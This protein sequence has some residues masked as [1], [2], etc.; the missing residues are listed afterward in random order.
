MTASLLR[1]PPPPRPPG[2]DVGAVDLGGGRVRNC[3]GG[4]G[5]V[6]SVC[7][8]NTSFLIVGTV[9]GRAGSPITGVSRRARQ[10]AASTKQRAQGYRL[11]AHPERRRLR[12]ARALKPG[13]RGAGTREDRSRAARRRNDPGVTPCTA[14]TARPGG[15][16]EQRQLAWR[17]ARRPEVELALVAVGIAQRRPL[18]I[19]A[20]SWRRTCPP[21]PDAGARSRR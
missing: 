4:G 18:V 3:C 7:W 16:C 15:T 5:A 2:V 14:S 12:S 11:R 19:D 6:V 13:A 21:F 17:E 1:L 20:P 8:S 10:R 9:G